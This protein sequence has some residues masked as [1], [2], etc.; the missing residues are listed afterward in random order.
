V[1]FAAPRGIVAALLSIAIV[2]AGCG[3]SRDPKETGGDAK[4]YA[5]KVAAI[6]T[7]TGDRLAAL[8]DQADYRDAQ[9]ASRSTRAY[10]DA[11]AK[12]AAELR[13]A[14]PPAA[15]ASL[16]AS[17][18]KLYVQTASAL[19]ALAVRFGAARDSVE[20]AQRAQELSS[21]VQRYS[22]QEQALRAA[23]ERAL[24]DATPPPRG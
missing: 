9:A 11:I 14:Q 12:A 8:S 19:G 24:A 23:I 22:S 7:A 1:S 21:A 15:A 4:A 16:H 13:R 10:A 18:V 3:G 20:L 6:S 5:T 17:L 2:L